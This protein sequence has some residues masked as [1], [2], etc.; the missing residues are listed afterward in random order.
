MSENSNF[1]EYG[2]ENPVV[3]R[4]RALSPPKQS[5]FESLLGFSSVDSGRDCFEASA[6]P[7]ASRNDMIFQVGSIETIA[8]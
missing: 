2:K 1:A 4:R 6:K 7:T 3:A 5:R 8:F